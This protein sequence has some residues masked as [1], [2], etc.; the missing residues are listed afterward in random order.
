MNRLAPAAMVLGALLGTHLLAGC[1]DHGCKGGETPASGVPELYLG[2]GGLP[3]GVTRSGPLTCDH[4]PTLVLQS[5]GPRRVQLGSR[6][7]A[8]KLCFPLADGGLLLAFPDGGLQTF[9]VDGG[10]LD[11][12]GLACPELEL[13]ATL[14]ALQARA[15][16]AGV[17]LIGLGIRRCSEPGS[18]KLEGAVQLD[19][20]ALADRTTEV[21]AQG[22]SDL[23]LGAT[24]GV[25]I[26]G[27]T[28]G[29]LQNE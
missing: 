6:N 1:I 12:G 17:R 20:W 27:V 3:P 16:R 29:C 8:G 28:I 13:D 25:A 15:S 10:P 2:D 14:I 9:D 23:R 5:S 22:L 18:P 26:E 19:D 4:A 24:F 21:V 11:D 7:N